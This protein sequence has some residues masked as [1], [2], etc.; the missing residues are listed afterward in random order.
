DGKPL[1]EQSLQTIDLLLMGL[2]EGI[3]KALER[4]DN[5]CPEDRC[6][7]ITWDQKV[8]FCGVFY[9]PFICDNF[10]GTPTEEI[11]KTR[12]KSDFCKECKRRGLHQFTG[13]Y[14]A[15]QFQ[16]KD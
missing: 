6:L 13:V 1:S 12:K 11:L 15:E 5:R 2:D 14:L 7:P 16:S 3:Q 4:R 9:N 10:L 8:R